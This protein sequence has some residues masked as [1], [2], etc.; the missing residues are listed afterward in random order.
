MYIYLA[1]YTHYNACY[2]KIII[3]NVLD[4][5]ALGVIVILMATPAAAAL[6]SF[7]GEYGNDEKEHP[8]MYLYQQCFL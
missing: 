8:S 3:G 4:G 7:A 1:F 5:I 2:N 6:P